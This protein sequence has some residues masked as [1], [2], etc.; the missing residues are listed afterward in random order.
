MDQK[1]EA[2]QQN[3]AADVAEVLQKNLNAIKRI[4]GEAC[5]Q[6][7]RSPDE[8]ALMAVSK[9]VSVERIRSLYELGQRL[10][11]ESY[12]QEL[13]DKHRALDGL[14]I[15]WS[16]IGHLQS[17][18]IKRI[19]RCADE[20]QALSSLKHAELVARYARELNKTPYPIY[21]AVNSDESATKSGI[22]LANARQFALDIQQKFPE[23]NVRGLM[24]VPPAEIQDPADSRPLVIPPLYHS[25]RAI[26][27]QIGEGRLSLG[28]SGDLRTAIAAGS[29]CVRV[30]TALFGDRIAMN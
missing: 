12:L 23:L 11:G 1:I 7:G 22:T 9:L 15:T 18:K 19:V 26:S 2:M 4:I 25:L 16:F 24:T 17:N 21:I 6:S 13:E 14:A 10:F 5:R 3:S 28:M 30:G 29:H 8:V 20:I 27:L